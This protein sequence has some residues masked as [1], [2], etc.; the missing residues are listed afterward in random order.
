MNLSHIPDS[1]YKDLH[2]L[3]VKELCLGLG[4]SPSSLTFAHVRASGEPIYHGGA[5]PSVVQMADT[6]VEIMD[7]VQG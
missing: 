5:I 2:D 6:F 3:M 4:V 7:Q 1:H